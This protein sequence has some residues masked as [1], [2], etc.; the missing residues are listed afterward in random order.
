MHLVER[1]S[2]EEGWLF[3]DMVDLVIIYWIIEAVS[4]D[5]LLKE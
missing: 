2:E 1:N 5:G 3:G 4:F